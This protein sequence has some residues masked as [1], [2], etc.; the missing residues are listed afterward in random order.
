MPIRQKWIVIRRH[1]YIGWEDSHSQLGQRDE[2]FKI[3]YLS[4]PPPAIYNWQLLPTQSVQLPV[5]NIDLSGSDATE[6]SY[7]KGQDRTEFVFL[8]FLGYVL[9][10][11]ISDVIPGCFTQF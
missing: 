4:S 7:S 5:I 10:L 1:V 11:T 2:N 6:K 3:W 9:T 8:G